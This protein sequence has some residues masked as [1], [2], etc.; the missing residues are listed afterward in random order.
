MIQLQSKF[1]IAAIHNYDYLNKINKYQNICEVIRK[2]LKTNPKKET[3]LK[4][5]EV[6]VVPVL[7]YGSKTWVLK[8]D[9]NASNI[10]EIHKKY[11]THQLRNEAISFELDLFP[12]YE[13]NCRI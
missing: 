2:V 5:V 7:L 9:C 1:L 6:M 11:W 10:N 13:E 8:R 3:T 12:L 4:F